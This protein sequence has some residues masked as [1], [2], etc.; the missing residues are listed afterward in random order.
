MSPRLAVLALVALFAL[1]GVLED[2]PT[3]DP[4]H[5]TTTAGRDNR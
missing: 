5:P 4:H 3:P 1:G 2:A